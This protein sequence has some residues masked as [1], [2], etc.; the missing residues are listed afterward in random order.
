MVLILE[1]IQKMMTYSK[2]RIKTIEIFYMNYDINTQKSV[3]SVIK[4]I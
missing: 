3:Y 4:T 1:N 2:K